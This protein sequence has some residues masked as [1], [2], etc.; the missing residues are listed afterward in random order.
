MDIAEIQNLAFKKMSIHEIDQDVKDNQWRKFI[1]APEIKDKRNSL[2]QDTKTNSHLPPH[3]S[4]SPQKLNEH[5]LYTSKFPPV[6][7]VP[8]EL[9][10]FSKKV[11][12]CA[13]AQRINHKQ[14]VKNHGRFHNFGQTSKIK[15]QQ[16]K[17]LKDACP[18]Y[19]EPSAIS[20]NKIK[21]W[22]QL[23][24]RKSSIANTKRELSQ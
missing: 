17:K 5:E 23:L 15:Q 12:L 11:Y 2:D 16:I 20:E 18:Y 7:N 4:L 24:S 3:N 9:A 21:L 13:Q 10:P 6:A 14:F 1:G 19:V 22:S 8:I